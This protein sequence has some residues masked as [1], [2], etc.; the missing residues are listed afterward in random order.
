ML[1]DNARKRARRAGL[2]FTLDADWIEERILAG[3]CEA[4]GLPFDLS[5][6]KRRP[7]QPSL[8]QRNP[9]RGYT[10]ENTEVVV[11]IYNNA[12]GD[13]GHGVVTAFA[14]AVVRRYP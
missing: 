1:L 8:D 9:G 6:Q 4:T 10:K 14:H 7:F 5:D 3:S 2:P 12:K 11:L 13:W